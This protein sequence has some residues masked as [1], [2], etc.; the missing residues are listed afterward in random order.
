MTSLQTVFMIKAAI[1]KFNFANHQRLE[2]ITFLKPKQSEALSHI[3]KNDTLVIIP[4]GYGKTLIF[5]LLPYLMDVKNATEDSMVIV[6]SPLDAII[7]Q[8]IDRLGPSATQVT[9]AFLADSATD[10]TSYRF[11]H[12]FCIVSVTKPHIV[13]RSQMSVL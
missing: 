9:D 3:I 7:Q 12:Y 6:A 2:P 13:G 10:P 8:Q 4:T 1:V 11:V 5:E